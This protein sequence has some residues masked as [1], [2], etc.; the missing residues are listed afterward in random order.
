MI[1]QCI[2]HS[3]TDYDNNIAMFDGENSSEHLFIYCCGSLWWERNVTRGWFQVRNDCFREGEPEEPPPRKVSSWGTEVDNHNVTEDR[4]YKTITITKKIAVIRNA[5]ST[6]S[7][8]FVAAENGAVDVCRYLLARSR[9][10]SFSSQELHN[11]LDLIFIPRHPLKNQ[12]VPPRPGVE[13]DE[14]A[15]NGFSPLFTAAQWA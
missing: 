7:L 3:G 4:C 12:C 2:A 13:V 1:F 15:N 10:S 5:I 14:P 8:L 9:F 11:D 6:L